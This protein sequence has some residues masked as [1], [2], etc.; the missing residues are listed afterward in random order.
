MKY[1]CLIPGFN[2]EKTIGWL[3]ESVRGL[4]YDVLVIDDGSRDRT[5][6]YA[7]EKGAEVMTNP[8][9]LGK[10]ASLRRVFEVA[11]QRPYD[12][13]I[14]MDADGQ[15]LPSDIAPFVALYE[16][17]RPGVIVGDR[18]HRSQGMPFVRWVTNGFMSW[19]ISIICRQRV[20]DTQ[21]GFRLVDMRALRAMKLATDKFE[22]ETEMLMQASDR[23]FK[24]ASV[25]ITT[26]YEGQFSAIH[27]FKDTLRFFR[28]I[29]KKR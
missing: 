21:C 7:R 5:A 20:P 27:P 19:M 8:Q 13:V 17:E 22:I 3:V 16:K 10:G 11:Q 12:A 28:L 23:G 15:H 2:E 26:V 25:P 9:N 6:L 14:V 24:I 1:L 4:G 18:M 29:F